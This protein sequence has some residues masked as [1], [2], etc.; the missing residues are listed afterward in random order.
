MAGAVI[1]SLS[2]GVGNQLFQYAAG[3]TVAQEREVPLQVVARPHL[4]TRTLGIRDLLD[5]PKAVLTPRERFL[6]GFPDAPLQRLPLTLKQPVKTFGRRAAGFL[7]FEQ[8]SLEMADPK[9][10]FDARH[11][12]ILLRGF[13]QHPTYYESVLPALVDE[14]VARLG[15]R[16]DIARGDG[17]VAMHF[18]RGD[19]VLNGYA[20]PLSF[21][22]D[23]LT[24]IARAHEFGRIVVM[25]DDVA[26]SALVAEHLRGRGF[27]AID[28]EAD[29]SR[30]DLDSFITLAT[31]QHVVMSNSTF[32]W[33]AAV[34]GDRIRSA[35]RT[36]VCPKP[37]MPA[38][39]TALLPVEKLDLSRKSWSIYPVCE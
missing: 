34:V 26:F 14:M 1:V 7:V 27:E 2:G 13:F 25:S 21:H 20:L 35:E 6:G 28:L 17:V 11:R 29:P 30:T 10:V 23:A 32:V 38:R 16:L 36:V 31:A 9:P 15:S 37:W 39:A 19:Y 8:T 18:R 5:V 24:E 12:T 3:R 22:D 4:A 33:W